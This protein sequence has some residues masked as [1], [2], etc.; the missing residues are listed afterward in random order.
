M[1]W[2]GLSMGV[3]D[4]MLLMCSVGGLM[5]GQ[6]F[7]NTNLLVQF[8]ERKQGLLIITVHFLKLQ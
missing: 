4:S 2:F 8:N 1:I 3:R 6:Q 7:M 5:S